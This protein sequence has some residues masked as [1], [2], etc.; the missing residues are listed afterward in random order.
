MSDGPNIII[1]FIFTTDVCAIIIHIAGGKQQQSFEVQNKIF[2]THSLG[3]V[4]L[5][6]EICNIEIPTK[7]ILYVL[8][9]FGKF[10][11]AEEERKN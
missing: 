2:F 8:K 3:L 4:H 7:W 6:R 11:V 10:E 1:S 9:W 5:N